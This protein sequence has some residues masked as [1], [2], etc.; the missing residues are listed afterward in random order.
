MEGFCPEY[1]PER[2]GRPRS[3]GASPTSAGDMRTR[4]TGWQKQHFWA[5]GREGE[6]Q[7]VLLCV[8]NKMSHRGEA[9]AAPETQTTG[10][11]TL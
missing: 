6:R 7:R 1:L 4:P 9:G 5:G 8:E 11:V 2:N 3:E 10:I